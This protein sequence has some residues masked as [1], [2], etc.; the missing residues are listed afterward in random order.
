MSTTISPNSN[1]TITVSTATLMNPAQSGHSRIKAV[2]ITNTIQPADAPPDRLPHETV[3]ISDRTP[4]PSPSV[5][6]NI[7]KTPPQEQPNT[8][9]NKSTPSS[10]DSSQEVNSPKLTNQ[11]GIKE[12]V[13]F[14]GISQDK[15][16]GET[17]FLNRLTAWKDG[18]IKTLHHGIALYNKDPTSNEKAADIHKIVNNNIKN[19]PVEVLK[20]TTTDQ[21]GTRSQFWASVFLPSRFNESRPDYTERFNTV[22]K[23]ANDNIQRVKTFYPEQTQSLIPKK[24]VPTKEPS[25]KEPSEKEPSKSVE[26]GNNEKTTLHRIK[27][28][29]DTASKTTPVTSQDTAPSFQP[30]VQGIAS[31]ELKTTQKQEQP[32]LPEN[33]TVQPHNSANSTREQNANTTT[34][35]PDAVEDKSGIPDLGA[36]DEGLTTKMGQFS[37]PEKVSTNNVNSATEPSLE[38][39]TPAPAPTGS[40]RPTQKQASAEVKT[41]VESEQP[42]TNP[43]E[44]KSTK[45]KITSFF[46]K[47]LPANSGRSAK[48]EGSNSATK[49]PD[50]KKSKQTITEEFASSTAKGASP[51]DDPATTDSLP[52]SQEKPSAELKTGVDSEQPETDP[53]EDKA[54]KKKKPGRLQRAFSFRKSTHPE[55]KEDCNTLTETPDIIKSQQSSSANPEKTAPPTKDVLS[56]QEG[57]EI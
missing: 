28:Y 12:L 8:E 48:T 51:T 31:D 34:T 37:L 52:S 40:P 11:K 17:N 7:G 27:T 43:S 5:S 26:Q 1:T 10:L 38:E 53:S 55:K 29:T 36:S 19:R 35:E 30:P 44:D 25:E 20:V 45:K 21:E 13:D 57:T 14:Y 42:E 2:P 46:K 54:T 15:E 33:Q 4:S 39:K 49:G 23:T 3:S 32:L 18:T 47:L 16:T 50:T 22:I 6:K 24:T 41:G 9:K 56:S